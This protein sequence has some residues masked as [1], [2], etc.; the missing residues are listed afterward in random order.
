[1]FGRTTCLVDWRLKKT[2]R[3]EEIRA[4]EPYS[5]IMLQGQSK[6]SLF[7]CS[8]WPRSLDQAAEDAN[9]APIVKPASSNTQ[10][11]P[12]SSN[13]Q[14]GQPPASSTAGRR[15]EQNIVSDRS[16]PYWWLRESV[17]EMERRDQE[18]AKTLEGFPRKED[19]EFG[20]NDDGTRKGTL[21]PPATNDYELA[22]DPDYRGFRGY[23][24]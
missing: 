22:H 14:L 12:T 9:R 3:S 11:K 2:T 8:S 10:R 5:G 7:Y 23:G 19:N 4:L 24:M 21:A 13:D 18:L 16:Y 6:R 17:L 20:I 1:M 15:P